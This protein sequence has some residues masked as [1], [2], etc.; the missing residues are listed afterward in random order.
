MKKIINVIFLILLTTFVSGYKYDVEITVDENDNVSM[1]ET[2]TFEN[3]NDLFV[4]ACPVGDVD[5]CSFSEP[6]IKSNILSFIG[7]KNKNL[8]KI[9]YNTEVNFTNETYPISYTVKYELGDIDDNTGSSIHTFNL[10][11][12]DFDDK[13]FSAEGLTYKLNFKFKTVDPSFTN[14]T[15]TLNIPTEFSRQ[16]GDVNLAKSTSWSLK[17]DRKFNAEFKLNSSIENAGEE[18]FNRIANNKTY[19]IIGGIV[20]CFLVIIFFVN[21]FKK[22]KKE[23]IKQAQENHVDK[24]EINDVFNSNANTPLPTAEVVQNPVNVMTEEEIKNHE[25]IISNKFLDSSFAGTTVEEMSGEPPKMPEPA[26]VVGEIKEEEPRETEVFEE[27]DNDVDLVNEK[28]ED[29]YDNS[30]MSSLAFGGTP[31]DN[32]NINEIK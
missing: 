17:N 30:N 21:I 8:D 18:E 6:I 3:Q 32:K 26:P 14:G 28:R 10:Y 7:E 23:E 11:E 5:E 12:M 22:C 24:F 29:S 15:V 13:L 2:A 31:L 27:L 16:N 25:D 9:K 1:T 19:F 4:I 20:A